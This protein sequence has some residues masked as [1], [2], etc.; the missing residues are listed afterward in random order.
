MENLVSGEVTVMLDVL[1]L[2]SVSQGLLKLLDDERCGVGNEL[3][4]GLSVLDGQ[5]GRNSNTFPVHGG[6]L[7]IFSDLLGGHT[8]RTDLGSKDGRSTNFTS[9]LSDVHNLNFSGVWLWWHLNR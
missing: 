6:L 2:L 4:S 7:D 8:K 3:D 9:V 1:G 5:L